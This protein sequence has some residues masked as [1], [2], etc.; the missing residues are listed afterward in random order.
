MACTLHVSSKT[1]DINLLVDIERLA[2]RARILK[3][4]NAHACTAESLASSEWIHQFSE[5][6]QRAFYSYIPRP[7]ENKLPVAS[8]R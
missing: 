5:A 8:E 7:G 6:I 4:N 3:A 1:R 2:F